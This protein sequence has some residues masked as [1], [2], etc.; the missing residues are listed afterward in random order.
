LTA[1]I[2]TAPYQPIA[3]EETAL[4]HY[5]AREAAAPPGAANAA[6]PS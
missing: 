1:Q 4:E 5:R 6:T 3:P 2:P